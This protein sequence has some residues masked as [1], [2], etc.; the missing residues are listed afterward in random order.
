MKLDPDT[1]YEQRLRSV[2]DTR[3]PQSNREGRRLKSGES[4]KSR[5]SRIPLAASSYHLLRSA[6]SLRHFYHFT[7]DL[8]RFRSMLRR[9]DRRFPMHL[10]DVWPCLE[11]RTKT[12]GFD[13]HYI[14]HTAWA[15][16]TLR[17]INPDYHIDIASSLPFVSVVSAFIPV[18]FYDYRPAQL[19][20]GNLEC[21]FADLLSLPFEDNSIPSLSCMHVVEHV[22]LG[23]YGDALDPNGDLK[24]IAEL[25]RVVALGGDLLFVVPIGKPRIM[26]NAHR[27]YAYRQIISS[28]VGFELKEFAL[29][30]DKQEDAALMVN[31]SE[32]T[33]N[34]QMGGCGCFWFRKHSGQGLS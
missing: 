31:A 12:T 21:G 10:M 1:Q 7:K 32:E 6:V 30:P 19:T 5:M 13:R 2:P 33:A 16:R 26:F 20:L 23:R 18:R 22:G 17:S 3:E 29:V 4:L 27:V 28:F 25:K 15:A 24:A 11:D 34:D 8:V 9:N 14:L